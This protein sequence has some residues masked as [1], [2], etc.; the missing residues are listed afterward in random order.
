MPFFKV[1]LTI[2]RMLRWSGHLKLCLPVSRLKFLI[3]SVLNSF[4]T[5][6][7]GTALKSNQEK[8]QHS[9]S[10]PLFLEQTAFVRRLGN[11]NAF[12]KLSKII[13]QLSFVFGYDY[14]LPS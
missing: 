8:V 12:L 2:Q 7:P 9:C 1:A 11:E 5:G 6:F 10:G 3:Q 4:V 14:L 13:R